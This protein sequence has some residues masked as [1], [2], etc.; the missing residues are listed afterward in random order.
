MPPVAAAIVTGWVAGLNL[1]P[2]PPRPIIFLMAMPRW[3]ACL[4]VA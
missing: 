1:A 3:L 4:Y 2:K